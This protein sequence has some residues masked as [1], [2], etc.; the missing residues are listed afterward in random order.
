MELKTTRAATHGRIARVDCGERQKV[1][2][3]SAT[4]CVVVRINRS[5]AAQ[6]AWA[7]HRKQTEN[8]QNKT[9]TC[10]IWRVSRDTCCIT[11][12]SSSVEWSI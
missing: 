9:L 10:E 5:H 6:I 3:G 7:G 2:A 4:V 1:A 12:A 8:R 11:P